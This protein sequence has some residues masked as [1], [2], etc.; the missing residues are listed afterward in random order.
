[1]RLVES[2]YVTLCDH[3]IERYVPCLPRQVIYMLKVMRQTDQLGAFPI[4]ALLFES[5]STVVK[6]A[7]H[8]QAIAVVIEGDQGYEDH[9]ERPGHD[10]AVELQ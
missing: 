4:S 9:I 6:A 7:T 8:A 10:D 2:V 3:G 1:M 5:K